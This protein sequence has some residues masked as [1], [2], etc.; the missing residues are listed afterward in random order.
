VEVEYA[1]EQKRKEMAF[2]LTAADGEPLKARPKSATDGMSKGEKKRAKDRAAEEAYAKMPNLQ[3]IKQSILVVNGLIPGDRNSLSWQMLDENLIGIEFLA[4]EKGN[5][6]VVDVITSVRRYM[7]ASEKQAYVIARFA[8][9]N[10]VTQEWAEPMK[11]PEPQ[12]ETATITEDALKEESLYD[13]LP[14]E[15]L[16]A[17]GAYDD[18]NRIEAI[19]RLERDGIDTG[20]TRTDEDYDDTD[21]EYSQRKVLRPYYEVQWQSESDNNNSPRKETTFAKAILEA[22]RDQDYDSGMQDYSNFVWMYLMPTWVDANGDEVEEVEDE[23]MSWD[24]WYYYNKDDQWAKDIGSDVVYVKEFGAYEDSANELRDKVESE[25]FDDLE[26]VYELPDGQKYNIDPVRRGNWGAGKY[27]TLMVKVP[28]K[29]E[30][31]EV[32]SIELRIADHSYN[33]RNVTADYFFSITIANRDATAGRFYGSHNLSFD[34]SDTYDEVVEKAKEYI[35][36]IVDRINRKKSLLDRAEREY[37]PEDEPALDTKTMLM[38]AQAR[39]RRVRVLALM[40]Q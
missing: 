12:K 15:V 23:Y 28:Y 39:A 40:E 13:Q 5:N 26:G 18:R 22:Q 8:D 37:I 30:D 17:L 10:G 32:E 29:G 6:F 21:P 25:I 36:E 24:D 7:K 1:N 2:N 11:F 38:L 9:E 35:I 16:D 14:Q 31:V 4:K 33:P 19:L 27:N 34:G 3:R 20:E